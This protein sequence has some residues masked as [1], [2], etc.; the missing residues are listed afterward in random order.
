MSAL[1]LN[2]P[3][4]LSKEEAL[5]RIKKLLS[6]LKEEQKDF[7]SDV[8]ENWAGDKGDFSFKAKGFNVAGN[9]IVNNSNVQLNSDLPFALSFF[10]ST[11][12]DVITKKA[13]TLLA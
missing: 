1:K 6:N 11:I 2:I 12:S 9:I 4:N 8:H 3:H 10:K 13:A 7:I 5:T